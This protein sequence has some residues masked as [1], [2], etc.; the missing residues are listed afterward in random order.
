MPLKKI[1]IFADTR[2][3][4]KQTVKI[5]PIF[6][7]GKTIFHWG[8]MGPARSQGDDMDADAN[9]LAVSTVATLVSVR[10]AL[11]E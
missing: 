1:S 9:L 8:F 6:Q 2:T 5:E 10:L 4:I 11:T 7:R 3:G